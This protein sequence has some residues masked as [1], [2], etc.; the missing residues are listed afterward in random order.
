MH[1]RY[2]SATRRIKVDVKA[3]EPGMFVCDL[4]RPWMDSPFLL[5]GFLLKTPGDIKNV[6]DV[7]NYVY[8]VPSATTRPPPIATFRS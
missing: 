3:L 5:Q 4:D 1:Q 8:V 7:C 6:R 2:I